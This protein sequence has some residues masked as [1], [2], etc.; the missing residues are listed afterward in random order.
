MGWP[1]G[2]LGIWSTED[3]RVMLVPRE[4]WG[5]AMAPEFAVDPMVWPV[6]D[7]VDPVDPGTD[8]VVEPTDWAC[9][10]PPGAEYG[11]D[12]D[13]DSFPVKNRCD[14]ELFRFILGLRTAFRLLWL[15]RENVAAR[16]D[17]NPSIFSA[18][19]SSFKPSELL[20]SWFGLGTVKWSEFKSESDVRDPD[21]DPTLEV[22]GVSPG[23]CAGVPPV[24]NDSCNN[25]VNDDTG[26]SVLIKF[27]VRLLVETD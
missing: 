1:L 3:D 20:L 27:G 25:R 22:V 4:S 10:L 26:R 13:N 6:A 14:I 21:K 8:P 18:A 9:S 17:S 15:P 5:A 12:D 23:V 16:G 24:S 2:R 7:P 11:I 19:L